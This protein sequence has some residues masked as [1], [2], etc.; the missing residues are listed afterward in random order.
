[1]SKLLGLTAIVLFG[2]AAAGCGVHQTEVP[3]L[4]GPSEFAL[5]LGLTATP[6]SI[7]LDGSASAVAVEAHHPDGTPWVGV[8]VRLDISVAGNVQDC[9]TLSTHNVV[10]GNDGRATTIYTAPSLPLPFPQCTG[11]TPGNAVTILAVPSGSNFQTSNGRSASIRMMPTGIILPPANSPTAA[12]TVSPTPATADQAL[13][14]DGSSSTPGTGASQISSYAW[15]FG[16][17]T[18]ATGVAPTH[19]YSASG[20]YSVTLTVTNDRGLTA[21]TTQAVAVAVAVVAANPTSNFTSSP[22]A[23]VV[24]TQVVFDASSSSAVPGA[25]ISSLAWN[26]GDDTPVITCPGNAACVGTRITAHT[27]ARA[28]IYTVNLVVTDTNNHAGSHAASVTIGSGNPT[29]V[30]TFSP[31]APKAGV[32][33]VNFNS[34]ASSASGSSTIA[35]WAW[36]FGD[37]NSD[38]SQ[39]PTHTFSTAGTY[40]VTLTVT[41]NASPG[42]TGTTSVTVTVVP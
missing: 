8:A 13:H 31:S 18:S 6:D 21:S 9:G 16:D 19:T 17:A 41:D 1:M 32:T 7:S 25:L 30:A 34:T 22:S 3:S 12:F 27:F 14:F 24:G 20:S 26:F 28:G 42:R 33:A 5:S 11:F 38:T 10:T 36:N 15:N 29:A 4:T 2:V 40:T 35:S 39:N 37:G 23:P